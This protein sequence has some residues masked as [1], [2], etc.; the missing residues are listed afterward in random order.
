MVTGPGATGG[1]QTLACADPARHAPGMLEVRASD[2]HGRGLFTTAPVAAGDVL[3]VAPALPLSPE[4][5]EVLG[6]TALE[7]YV[8]DWGDGHTAVAFGYVSLCNHGAPSNAEAQVEDAPPTVHLVATADIA[9]G[10]EIL[11]DYGPDHVVG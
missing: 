4:D 9:A 3:E 1:D 2:R 10:A 11:L 6:A 5:T 7:H 8:F